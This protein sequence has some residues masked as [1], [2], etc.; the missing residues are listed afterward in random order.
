LLLLAVI[1][2]VADEHPA[3][4]ASVGPL[5]A[6]VMGLYGVVVVLGGWVRVV[7]YSH[8]VNL[9]SRLAG[10]RGVSPPAGASYVV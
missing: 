10:L 7:R 2:Y 4:Y 5:E 8:D 6:G 3:L 9:L 1:V